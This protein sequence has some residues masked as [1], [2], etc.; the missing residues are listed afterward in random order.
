L[1]LAGGVRQEVNPKLRDTNQSIFDG[2]SGD[3]V[4]HLPDQCDADG[5][6]P[7]LWSERDSG[8]EKEEKRQKEKPRLPALGDQTAPPGNDY[9]P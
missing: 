1:K 9:A 8:K 4:H 7:F 5:I 3:P 6:G 2:A